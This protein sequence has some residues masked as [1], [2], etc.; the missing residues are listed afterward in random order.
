MLKNN[1]L[2]VYFLILNFA[3]F[4]KFSGKPNVLKKIFEIQI[5]SFSIVHNLTKNYQNWRKN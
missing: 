2:V 1:N 4:S 5:I 3:D